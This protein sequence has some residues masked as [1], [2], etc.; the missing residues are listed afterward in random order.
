MLKKVYPI[1]VHCECSINILGCENY[2]VR[3]LKTD[4]HL[5]TIQVHKLIY[6]SVKKIVFYSMYF[7]YTLKSFKHFYLFQII[8]ELEIEYLSNYFNHF[9]LVNEIQ[10]LY[11]IFFNVLC[12]CVCVRIECIAK[13]HT[14]TYIYKHFKVLYSHLSNNFHLLILTLT[15]LSIL[16]T[17]VHIFFF[18]L[19]YYV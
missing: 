6:L 2:R 7:K 18:T 3:G 1:L 9:L 16:S 5:F 10:I 17:T 11:F 4:K 15:F 19:F 14:R 13:T 12:V 8:C